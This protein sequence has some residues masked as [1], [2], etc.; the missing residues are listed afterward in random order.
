MVSQDNFNL[1]ELQNDRD[2]FKGRYERR[3]KLIGCVNTAL[4]NEVFSLKQLLARKEGFE[5][6]GSTCSIVDLL[7]LID[8]A[9]AHTKLMKLNEWLRD[10]YAREQVNLERYYK[11]KLDET[12]LRLRAKDE[13][14]KMRFH[15]HMLSGSPEQGAILSADDQV[16]A[17]Q[18]QM[19]L[20]VT[21]NEWKVHLIQNLKM[22]N[23]RLQRGV[24]E[25]QDIISLV[26][27]YQERQPSSGRASSIRRHVAGLAGGSQAG[28]ESILRSEWLSEPHEEELGCTVGY[29]TSEECAETLR[30]IEDLKQAVARLRHDDAIQRRVL[31][32]LERKVAEIER[33]RIHMTDNLRKDNK[34][35]Y[36]LDFSTE[37]LNDPDLSS[38]A[39]LHEFESIV[40]MER[41]FV[42]AKF[43]M[44]QKQIRMLET[45]VAQSQKVTTELR[46]LVEALGTEALTE[47]QR[48]KA[49]SA[50]SGSH[51]AGALDAAALART[52]SVASRQTL[53]A[54]LARHNS[55]GTVLHS[56]AARAAAK[57]E[58][59][60]QPGRDHG[61]ALTVAGAVTGDVARFRAQEQEIAVLNVSLTAL[62]TETA[63]LRSETEE[64]AKALA[65]H[66]ERFRKLQVA[67]RR[68]QVRA[69]LFFGQLVERGT[70][71]DPWEVPISP[72][73]GAVGS[74]DL[75]WVRFGWAP[76]DRSVDPGSVPSPTN[77]P[78]RGMRSHTDRTLVLN[79]PI[80]FNSRLVIP[81]GPGRPTLL[82]TRVAIA[83][84]LQPP[85]AAPDSRRA[86]HTSPRA[87]SKAPTVTPP[88]SVTPEA[89]TL[90]GDG[91]EPPSALR[92]NE[93]AVY[94]PPATESQMEHTQPRPGSA[95]LHTPGLDLPPPAS[96]SL[97]FPGPRLGIRK[98][99][100]FPMGKRT[101]S[102]GKP[103][104]ATHLPATAAHPKGQ[105]PAPA[106]PKNRPGP[107]S[108][109][110]QD[111][112][113]ATAAAAPDHTTP[114]TVDIEITVT[115]VSTVTAADPESPAVRE[116]LLAPRGPRRE[117]QQSSARSTDTMEGREAT[118]P[119]APASPAASAEATAASPTASPTASP[120]GSPTA[121]R[122]T[123]R[124]ATE[125]SSAQTAPSLEPPSAFEV[126]PT[127]AVE[128]CHPNILAFVGTTIVPAE[129]LC[130]AA[131]APA[132]EKP[133]PAAKARLP[134]AAPTTVVQPK[135]HLRPGVLQPA[136]S[137]PKGRTVRRLEA[138]HP[139]T[140]KAGR[141]GAT[142]FHPTVRSAALR[143]RRSLAVQSPDGAVPRD[144]EE[145][146]ASPEEDPQ[147]PSALTA[148]PREPSRQLSS[149]CS[150]SGPPDGPFA[151]DSAGAEQS[152]TAEGGR[153]LPDRT[154]ELSTRNAPVRQQVKTEQPEEWAR[155]RRRRSAYGSSSGATGQALGPS[156][157]DTAEAAEASGTLSAALMAE[158]AEGEAAGPAPLTEDNLRTCDASFLG[159][160]SQCSEHTTFS[161]TRVPSIIAT[162]FRSCSSHEPEDPT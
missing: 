47:A 98:A 59:T 154:V 9:E 79:K 65:E 150:L 76:S 5:Y 60:E 3:T 73:V 56:H 68:R 42:T 144:G 128:Y 37:H 33:L 82:P 106:S 107:T 114:C 18:K 110:P 34:D 149:Q 23:R 135:A 1:T 49:L 38:E 117:S 115:D 4:Y 111:T 151:T 118:A 14:M 32:A 84:A 35:F 22:E 58:G 54:Q 152:E 153:H 81:T 41:L 71:T 89:V 129:A 146:E 157:S 40:A 109:P 102:R 94:D 97:V 36:R 19:K 140:A 87:G 88:A 15:D 8:N 138:R 17:L 75:R 61:A 92:R 126:L 70:M 43:E 80:D 123:R 145:E 77:H 55:E 147:Q 44:K 104:P 120:V 90:W 39:R 6:V 28:K 83:S 13:E 132:P 74:Q 64:Q 78:H 99:S 137:A 93:S 116:A 95:P 52:L 155:R 143:P 72:S 131:D 100:D 86:S 48:A 46:A 162:W 108:S 91:A 50:A 7:N 148:P 161:R 67:F 30:I 25:L 51:G 136:A 113:T 112:H 85:A 156:P 119:T 10:E 26:S 66:E 134:R 96:P 63:A 139:S 130:E 45:K 127:G 142:D 20:L 24:H 101:S 62:R 11:A 158:L 125:E 12:L 31:L 2:L 57:G 69:G 133:S 141:G 103:P 105:Q 160:R 53:R 16:Q 121:T 27:G 159:S 29:L 124:V 122:P 21:Q